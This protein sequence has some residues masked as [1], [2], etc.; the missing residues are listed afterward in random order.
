MACLEHYCQNCECEWFDNKPDA[1]C[2]QCGSPNVATYFDE[3]GD[4]EDH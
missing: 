1:V 2:I 3:E 4:H